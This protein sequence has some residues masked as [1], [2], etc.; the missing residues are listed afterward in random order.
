MSVTLQAA[1]HPGTHFSENL[2]SIR[3]QS[4]KSLRQLF[5]VTGKLITDQIDITGIPVIERQQQMWQR[6]TLLTDKAVQFATA[7]TLVF[8]ESVLCLGGISPDPVRA[9]KDK[10]NWFMESH[11]FKELDRI[12]GSRWSSS[13]KKFPG[14]TPLGSLDEIQKMMTE[15][16]CEPE[17]FK[18]RIILMSMYN[19]I[20]WTKK[21]N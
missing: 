20:D 9:W 10:I 2:P 21:E 8:S 4:K 6:T 15:S 14:F 7:K 17:Q 5:Q 13:G 12:G 16:M 1:V 3:N 19:D 18:G 11:S